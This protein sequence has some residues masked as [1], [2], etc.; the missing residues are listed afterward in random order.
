MCRYRP[1]GDV[2][3]FSLGVFLFL[4]LFS[5]SSSLRSYDYDA[6]TEDDLSFKK[7][8]KLKI[9]NNSDGDWWQA[10]LWGSSQR[11]YIPSN[12]VAECQSIEAEE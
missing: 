7:G 2:L 11:G 8:Q 5:L 4:F 9:L 10:E 12:Y 1:R 6:R 3:I